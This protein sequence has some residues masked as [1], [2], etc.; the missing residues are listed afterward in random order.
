[1][2]SLVSQLA[3]NEDEKATTNME[4]TIMELISQAYFSGTSHEIFLNKNSG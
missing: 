3:T 4:L 1:M 2:Y